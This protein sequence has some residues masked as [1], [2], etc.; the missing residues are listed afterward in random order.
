MKTIYIYLVGMLPLKLIFEFVN[1]RAY[2]KISN[3]IFMT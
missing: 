3:H 2:L 1:L